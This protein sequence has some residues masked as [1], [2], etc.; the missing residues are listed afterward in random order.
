MRRGARTTLFVDLDVPDAPEHRITIAATHL[1]NR[2]RPKVRRQQMEELLGQVRNVSNPVV[3][4]GDL[5]TTGSDQTPTSVP[6]YLYNQFGSTDFWATQG[7]QW[8]TGLGLVYTGAKM[9]RK[10]AGIQ[11]RVDPTSANL[12]GLSPNMERGLFDSMKRFRFADGKALDFRGVPERTVNGRGGTLGDSNERTKKGFEPTFVTEVIGV[13]ARVAKF[14]LD[15][16]LVKSEL[17]NPGDRNGP[18]L[19]APHFPRTLTDLNNCTPEEPLSDHSPIMVDLP[20]HEPPNLAP[21]K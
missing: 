14:R 9:G 21:V 19:F 16:I 1:E 8:A 20:F 6:R 11:Y 7:I 13:K 2:A 17:E 4:A 18:Y 12:P 3:I 15:W 5:N 10:L